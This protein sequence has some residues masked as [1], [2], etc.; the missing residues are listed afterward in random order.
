MGQQK[1]IFHIDVNSA[2]LSWESVYRLTVEGE[3]QDLRLIPSIVGGDREQRHGVV[4]AKST[5]AKKFGVVTGEPIT[6]ALQKCPELLIVPSR[7][8]IYEQYSEQFM[9]I[10]K[11]YS[12][13]VEQYSID[14]AFMDMTGMELLF[15]PPLECAYKIKDRIK[16]E[17]GFTVNVGISTNHLLAKM[18]GDLKKPDMVHTLF[19]EEIEKKMWPLPVE[20]LFFVGKAT[21]AKLH[22]L[23]IHTIGELANSDRNMLCS[24]LKSTGDTIWKFANGIDEVVSGR[25]NQEAKGY[26]NETTI[27]HDV[28][29]REEA[30]EILLGLVEQVSGRLRAD[31]KKAEVVSV[32][33]KDAWFVSS[34]HQCVLPNPTAGTRELYEHAC[35]LLS[36]FWDGKPIR[37]LNFYASRIT[38]EEGRQLTMFDT[39]DYEKQE[40]ADAAMDAIREKFGAGAIKRAAFL[41]PGER[42]SQKDAE[43]SN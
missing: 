2:F 31:G 34:S 40:K 3:T 14:E 43:K 29:E 42:A 7:H 27:A 32:G 30:E 6:Q 5:P 8:Y 11:E 18:A 37:L 4:L 10:L 15:G 12:P 41:K 33:I 22:T 28:T 13:V 38:E 39:T 36:E 1:I 35:R 25:K 26:S 24:H 19:P 17:L 9:V 21:A 16:S 23:G 20:D